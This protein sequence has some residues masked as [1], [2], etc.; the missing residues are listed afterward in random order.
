M[1][2][3]QK[4]RDLS[5]DGSEREMARRPGKLLAFHQSERDS[6]TSC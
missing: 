3:A 4:E 5:K 2:V 6:A 1:R